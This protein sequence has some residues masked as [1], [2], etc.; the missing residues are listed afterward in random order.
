MS[1]KS[2]GARVPAVIERRLAQLAATM[3]KIANA[4]RMNSDVGKPVSSLG[5]RSSHVPIAVS[6]SK[7]T[8]RIGSSVAVAR[9]RTIARRSTINTNGQMRIESSVS[10]KIGI[11][12]SRSAKAGKA[13]L[14]HRM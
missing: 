10:W 13:W 8:A 7:S 2:F 5:I 3:K 6:V 11:N 4:A 9:A 1:P 12:T 14:H